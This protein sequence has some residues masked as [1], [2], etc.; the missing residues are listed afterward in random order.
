MQIFLIFLIVLIFVLMITLGGLV[1]VSAL[2]QPP[3]SDADRA[4]FKPPT[5]ASHMEMSGRVLELECL[6]SLEEGGGRR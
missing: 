4:C 2:G 3:L 5:G 1:A 6:S